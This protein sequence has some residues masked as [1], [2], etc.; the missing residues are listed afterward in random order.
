MAVRVAEAAV[1]SLIVALGSIAFRPPYK[2]NY[3]QVRPILAI[4]A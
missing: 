2:G 3:R 4:R 1:L